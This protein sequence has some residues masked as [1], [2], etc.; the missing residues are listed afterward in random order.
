MGLLPFPVK[1]PSL[2]GSL[3]KGPQRLEDLEEIQFHPMKAFDLRI[4]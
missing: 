4:F 2:E 3:F 1:N